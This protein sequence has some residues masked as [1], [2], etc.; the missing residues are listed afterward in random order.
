MVADKTAHE[1][2]DPTRIYHF[3]ASMDNNNTANKILKQVQVASR[4]LQDTFKNTLTFETD[5][6]LAECVHLGRPPQVMQISVHTKD[7]CSHDGLHGC[8]HQFMLGTNEQDLIPIVIFIMMM[9][10]MVAETT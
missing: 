5:L 1:Y 4:I 10:M 6:Q 8:T 3:G 9:M 7:L 2:I